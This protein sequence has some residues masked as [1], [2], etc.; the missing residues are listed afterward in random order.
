MLGMRNL[1]RDIRVGLRVLAGSPGFAA[2]AA[3][4]LGLG[5][6]CTTTVFSW[7]DTIL[8]RPYPGAGDVDRLA[9]L[10]MLTPG[11]P[12]GGTR[13][14]WLDYRD[15]RDRLRSF[16]GLA[17]HRQCAFTLGEG[18]AARLTWGE[19]VTG[20]FFDV[21]QVR[22][23]LGRFFT[24]EENGDSPGAYPVAVISTRL[25]RTHFQGDHAIVGK[26][27]RINRHQLT[28][29]G[30][31]P[32]EF[33]GSSPVM[34]YDLW[35]PVTMG[36]RLG[37]LPETTFRERND[38]GMLDA[39]GRLRPGVTVEQARAEAAALAANLAAANPNTNRGTG[40]TVLRPWEEHNGVNEYLRGPLLIL[41]AV[42][43]VVLLV[44]CANVAN[45]LLARSV[46]RQ[47]EFGI[48]VALGAGQSRVACQVLTETLV[49]AGCGAVVGILILMWM[50]GSLVGMAP[51][52]GFPLNTGLVLNGRILAF[53]AAACVAAALFSGASPALFVF[54]ANLNDVLKDGGRGD[55][56]GSASRRTRSLLVVGEV[57]LATVALVA[58]GLFVRSF[59]NVRAVD[60]GFNPSRVL[61]GR[62]F[63]ETAGYTGDQT[64]QFCTRLKERVQ[65]SSGVEA[66]SYTDFVPLSST[67]GPYYG[68]GVDGYTPAKGESMNVNRVLVAPDY[69]AAMRIPILE[70]RDFTEL[71]DRGSEPVVIVNQSFARRFFEGQS[72]LG[73]KVRAGGK[74]RRVVGL[75]RDSKYFSPV[76]APSPH[77]YL[78]FRQVYNSS[79][80]IYFLARTVGPPEQSIPLLRRAVAETDGRAAAFHATPLADY[81]EVSTFGQKVAASLMAALGVMC[82]LL[83]ASGLYSVM[84]YTVSQRIPE[85]GIRMAMGANPW[86]V[87]RM[88][89][90]QGMLLA[91][92][93]IALGSAAALAATRLVASM[94]FRVEAR[95]PA[96]FL[97]SGAFLAAVALAATWL[98]AFRATRANPVAA[99]RR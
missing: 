46:A 64:L 18:P 6:A 69:F 58:A 41:M 68:V 92:V 23:A 47:K 1:S 20:N 89:V 22:P 63:I 76:E 31:A 4:T 17:L 82:L 19:L 38:R 15:Y 57:A 35:T 8:L 30:V 51:P 24:P 25:W 98:P 7:I 50:Q 61:L 2:V 45:L 32:P 67:A 29:V 40:A 13:L 26:T 9:V 88:V 73:R 80:E 65:A 97:L 5:I 12:N 81:T 27:V 86:D 16:S 10:E 70:G 93:G 28:I 55:T 75:A 95:D 33:H 71:D 53:T 77:F 39:F 90:A 14:S 62:F 37:S 56:A 44:V 94:L 21:L 84:S 43:S 66:A 59:Q 83:A 72:P 79:A 99:L 48:R 52:V 49:L 42:A 60:P 11:A 91:L 54:H 3:L 85:I 74:W 96:T 34:V 78:P 36:G 87:V